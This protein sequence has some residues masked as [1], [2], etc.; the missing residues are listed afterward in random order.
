MQVCSCEIPAVIERRPLPVQ[1]CEK[2]TQTG[3]MTFDPLGPR[4][5]G[6]NWWACLTEIHP[7]LGSTPSLR[8]PA[9]GTE[10][11]VRCKR[12]NKV[13]LQGAKGVPELDQR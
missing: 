9:L 12:A 7:I 11:L 6:V 3:D 1:H 8:D 13:W 5:H 10:V 2:E 4:L